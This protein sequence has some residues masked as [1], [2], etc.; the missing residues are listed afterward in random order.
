VGT[1]DLPF[2]NGAVSLVARLGAL[3]GLPPRG[4]PSPAAEQR[5]AALAVAFG[6]LVAWPVSDQVAES[7][8]PSRP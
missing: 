2:T 5:W 4:D 1:S 6:A 7:D 8:Q 3:L